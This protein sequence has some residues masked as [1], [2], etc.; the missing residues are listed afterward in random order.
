MKSSLHR[1]LSC[2]R[3]EQREAAAVGT[4]VGTDGGGAGEAEATGEKNL[5]PL[6]C[7]R[8]YFAS[9]LLS[10]I[11]IMVFSRIMACC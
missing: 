6:I 8:F 1:A 3:A 9:F 2:G 11:S 7:F 10:S 4:T 5:S